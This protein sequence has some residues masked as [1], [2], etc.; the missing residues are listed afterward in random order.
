M[1]EQ[2]RQLFERIE[3]QPEEVQNH[4]AEIVRQELEEEESGEWVPTPEELAA[5]E[6]SDVEYAAGMGRSYEDYVRERAARE[7]P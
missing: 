2:L 1:V 4:I 7:G 5:I 6:A 3:R